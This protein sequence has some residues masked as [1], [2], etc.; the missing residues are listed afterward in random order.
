M[1]TYYERYWQKKEILEDFHYKWPVIKKFIPTKRNIHIL[2]FGCGKGT[3]LTEMQKINPHAYFT[4][5]DVSQKALNF[6]KKKDKKTI[7]R[8]ILDGGS[9][10]FQDNSFDFIIASDVL[11]H[12][13]DTENAFFELSRVLKN[14]GKIL[15][16]V[17]YNGMIKRTLV[18]LFFFEFIFEPSTPH[19]RLYTKNSLTKYLNKYG[20]K[21]EKVGYYG[22]FFPF[23]NG[24]Y[25]IG[26]KNKK[27]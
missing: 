20:I 3:I 22:R 12:V 17:P 14:K 15:I 4:A 9:M 18:A 13:Y 2:D 19:I 27:K 24:M 23:S 11:E 26:V 10:P 8:K 5:V 1:K 16:S 7:L 21:V 25:M 6:I